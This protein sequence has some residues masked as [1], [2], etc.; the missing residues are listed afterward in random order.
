MKKIIFLL[1][2]VLGAISATAQQPC[3]DR[4]R[5]FAGTDQMRYYPPKKGKG[6]KKVKTHVDY[7]PKQVLTGVYN[8]DVL[9]HWGM[10]HYTPNYWHRGYRQMPY[11]PQ[12]LQHDPEFYYYTR[13]GNTVFFSPGYRSIGVTVDNQIT[14]AAVGNF[15]YVWETRYGDTIAQ[16]KVYNGMH[17]HFEVQTNY[18]V[19]LAEVFVINGVRRLNWLTTSGQVIETYVLN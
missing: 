4:N 1:I 9:V 14:F 16:L 7:N 17:R 12:W 10:T 13:G 11:W 18:G 6:Y 15:I 3:Y 2:L 5:L 8:P 19:M